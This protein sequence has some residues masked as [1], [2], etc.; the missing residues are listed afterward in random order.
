LNALER[1]RQR[2]VQLNRWTLRVARN[3]LKIAL[4]AVGIFAALPWVA[5]TLMHLGL[6]APARTLYTVY[7]PFCHQFAFRS[8]FLYGD[9]AF[10]PRAVSGTPLTPFEEETAASQ[11]WLEAVSHWVGLPGRSMFPTVAD[12]DPFVWSP[13]LQFASREFVGNPQMGY[14]TTLC[15]RDMASYTMLFVGIVIYSVPAVRR[16]LRPAPIFLYVL[17]GLAPI[18]IDGMSQL[19]GYPPFNL[20]QPRET[21]PIFRVVTGGLFGFMNAWLGLPYLEASFQD[22]RRQIE[23]KLARAGFPI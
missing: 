19:L 10:Y 1:R 16:R 21:D 7:S 5:P 15:A 20:W 11:E 6:T 9:Q 12:F 18:G 14:K 23:I 13:D 3:W 22:T 17:L 2:T 4:V 8:I